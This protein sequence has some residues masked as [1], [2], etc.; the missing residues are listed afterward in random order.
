[1]LIIA[2]IVTV[3]G[4]AWYGVSGASATGPRLDTV[5][6][7]T[8]R[9]ERVRWR[10]GDQLAFSRELADD[11]VFENT[12]AGPRFEALQG[13]DVVT[14]FVESYGRSWLDHERFRD[15]A[16]ERL[17]EVE[18]VLRDAGLGIRSG[19]VDSPIRGGRSWLA[20]AS[21]A[22]GLMLT[23]QA[24]FDRLLSSDRVPLYSLLRDAG[25]TSVVALPVVSKPWVE[26][27]WYDVDTFLN[28]DA[29]S[30]RGKDFG[31]VTMPDQYTLTAFEDQVRDVEEK[32]VAGMIGL[33][34][35]HAPWGPLPLPVPWEAV[36]DGSV[37]DGSYRD[38]GPISWATPEPVRANYSRSL[39]RLMQRLAEYLALYADDALFVIIGDHQP[40]SVIAGWA[41]N[42]HVPVHIIAREPELLDR[43]PDASF[44]DGAIPGEALAAIPM[45]DMRALLASIYETPLGTP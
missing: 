16:H 35:S 39:D 7:F 6:D 4:F 21:Y 41:P 22:S 19:W 44:S 11:P 2:V 5:Q 31:Y 29:L 34:D 3:V 13:R 40:A 30:Y 17:G 14:L 36:G 12:P 38:G 8:K 45:G 9:F 18:N 25:W 26:G 42:A 27:A 37:F 23:S 1:M 10:I 43:L 20:Q 32:P 33:L 15:T 24:R 28:R